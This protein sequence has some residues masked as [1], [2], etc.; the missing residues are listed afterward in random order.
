MQVEYLQQTYQVSVGRACRLVNLARSLYYYQGQ[1]KDDT[2]IEKLQQ[3]V[4]K[5]P[6]E[7]F[8]KIHLRLR[9]E[10]L[11]WNH[12]RV[13]RI[14]KLL[15]FH[16]KRKG[17]RRLAPRTAQ[18]LEAVDRINVC[19][20]MDFM[21]D[22]LVSGRRFRVLNLLDD[23]NREALVIEIDTSFRAERVIR[24]LEQTIDWRGKPKRLRVDNGPEF[25]SGKLAL[26]CE[27]QEII[28]QFIQ[29]GK[30]TQ[31]AYIERFNGS[32]RRDILDVYLF[33]NLTQVRLLAQ[34]WMEDYNCYRPHDA[35]QGR[36]PADLLVTD[37]YS[38]N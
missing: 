35:L 28:L 31:N 20:S 4:D 21:S 30:P 26:W 33:E 29:P 32:F 13:Y 38:Q 11:G 6:M 15:N 37:P 24:V 12:K 2:V 19:W 36:S 25:I 3:M 18:P 34:E 10:G 14:Y 8:W 7:G 16:K 22:A 17:K 23:F 5:R 1:K 9:K 27:Q